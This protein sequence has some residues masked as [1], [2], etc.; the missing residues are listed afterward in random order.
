MIFDSRYKKIEDIGEGVWSNVYKVKDLRTDKIYT[1]KLFNHIDADLIYEK[2]SAED[3]HHITKLDHPNLL[4]II[5]FGN[6]GNH[7]YYLSDYY[8]GK[9]LNDFKYKPN[10]NEQFY[11]IVAQICYALDALHSQGLIHKDLKLENILYK[12]VNNKPEI[13]VLDYGFAKIDHTKNQQKVTGTLPYIAPEILSGKKMAVFQ[14]DFYSLGVTLYKI[15]TG[16]S[17]YSVEQISAVMAGNPHNFFPKFP[18]EIN[19]ECPINIEKLILKLLEK[20]PE[21]RFPDVNSIINFINKMQITKKFNFSHK[22]SLVNTMKHNSYIAREDYS[23]TLMDYIPYLENGNGKTVVLLGGDGQGKDSILTLFEYHLLTNKYF[24]FDYLCTKQDKDPFFA[25]INEFKD[26]ILNN[27]KVQTELTNISSKFRKYLNNSIEEASK[28]S[29]NQE[30]LYAD[31]TSA[32]SFLFSLSEE[33]P[34]IFIIRAEQYISPETISFINLAAFEMAKKPIMIILSIND[35]HQTK[36]LKHAIYLKV[37]PLSFIDTKKYLT[38]LLHKEVP[39]TFAQEIHARSFGIPMFVRDILIDL[40]EKKMIWVKEKLNFDVDLKKYTLPQNLIH[41]IYYRMSHL[42]EKSYNNLQKLS[43]IY[44]PLSKDL[45]NHLLDLSEEK[46]LWKLLIDA[47]N[48]EIIYEQDGYYHFTFQEIRE[49]LNSEL[50]QDVRIELSK[51][52]IQYY[53][54]NTIGNSDICMGLV[55]NAYLAD[56]IESVRRFKLLLIDTYNNTYQQD[57]A[58]AEICKVIEID[59]SHKVTVPENELKA[60]LESFVNKAEM[61]GLIQKA[62]DLISEIPHFPEMFEKYYLLGTLMLRLEKYSSAEEYLNIAL[63]MAMTGKYRIKVLIDLVW[64]YTNNSKFDK[65]LPILND[66]NGMEMSMELKIAYIDRESIYLYR[67][68]RNS[69][70]ITLL[71]KFLVDLPVINETLALLK[72]GSLYNNLGSFYSNEKNIADAYKHFMNAKAIWEKLNY[73]RSLGIVYNNLGDLSLRQG[74]T[75]NALE[76]FEKALEISN[77]IGVRRSQVLAWLNFGET[78][79]KLGQFLKAEEHL[80]KAKEMC[81]TLESKLFYEGIVYNLAIVRSKIGS[82]KYYLDFIKENQPELLTGQIKA[83]TPLTKTYFY[84]LFETGQSQKINNL[85]YNNPHLDFSN[86]HEE[87]FYY[88]ILGLLSMHKRDYHT[89]LQNINLALEQSIKNKS[90]YAQAIN[91]IRQTECYLGLNR[92]ENAEKSFENA[93]QLIDNYGFKYWSL[94]LDILS[95][96]IQ[97]AQKEIPL[98]VLL[99]RTLELIPV[100]EKND[101]Y[102]LQLELYSIII[103]I[104]NDLKAEKLGLQYF[105]KYKEKVENNAKGLPLEDQESYYRITKYNQT[106]HHNLHIHEV[107]SRMRQNKEKWQEHLYNLLKLEELSRI[108]FSLDKAITTLLA[109]DF[110]GIVLNDEIRAQSPKL[111]LKYNC[112]EASLLTHPYNK[113]ILDSIETD[114]IIAMKLDFRH[115][116]FIPLRLKSARVGCLIIADKGELEF[117]KQDISLIKMLKLHLTTMLIRIREFDELNNKMSLVTR[118]MQMSQK[119]LQILDQDKLEKQIVM[120]GIE[121]LRG[122]RGFMIIRDAFGNYS[123]KIS[124]DHKNNLLKEQKNISMTVVGDVQNAMIPIYTHNILEDSIYKSSNSLHDFPLASIYCAPVTIDNNLHCILYF[125]SLAD[126]AEELKINREIVSMFLVQAAVAIKNAM[127]YESLIKKNLELK[128]LDTT[129]DKF[130]GIVSH[131][132]NTPL[133]TLKGYVN[134]LKKKNFMDE[135]ERTETLEK[136]EKSVN[137]LMLS[138]KDIVLLNK[139]NVMNSIPFERENVENLL[140]IVFSEA[141]IINRQYDRHMKFKMEIE[142]NLP[143][144]EVNWE[145]FHLMIYS[146][147]LNS[148]RFTQDFG[149]ITMGVRKATFPQEKIND[150]DGVVIYIQDNG[151][152]IP[153]HELTNIFKSFYELNDIYSHRSGT[154]EYRSSGL[155]LGLAISN[156]IAELHN[157]KIWV[158]SKE[159]EGTTVFIAFSAYKKDKKGKS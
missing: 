90:S 94:V 80:C 158:N 43:C 149:F 70:A 82:F 127:Q 72:L 74:D 83:L 141:E 50:D 66:L 129:K 31:F 37:E 88:Q 32:K 76:Y 53:K 22:W 91:Y 126:E 11:E 36:E 46:E 5:K 41:S 117:R 12:V 44:S 151:T 156:R 57:K 35:P 143:D 121:L 21:D 4:H 45:I 86:N 159:N 34:L 140:S 97:L 102:A 64:L 148:I 132:L 48:N 142:S 58:F 19:P 120:F 89:A 10:L 154:V 106:D 73:N 3:M 93:K 119:M 124:L 42:N 17:P 75:K 59:F 24:V 138:I 103:Q 105:R 128:T 38:K 20:N 111:F 63:N 123:F 85:L 92:F 68:G 134:K 8:D 118:I 112:D 9:P 144:I 101:I 145:G 157:A 98:R 52:F 51:K 136:V 95:I 14:S 54:E 155:G 65:A 15:M 79:I 100:I 87:E 152:G 49:R 109:P 133:V 131:E 67:T 26:Y 27:D 139:Y 25:L 33:R 29:E 39:E 6:H 146:I 61:T 122:R 40:T 56:D 28:L 47:R 150:Q 77:K 130:I 23:H 147:I 137:K 108:K 116:L 1:L 107:G 115:T 13:K 2:L 30:E 104:Y 16:T 99:R 96:K 81:L 71:E 110:Y 60:D 55:Q 135:N 78:Y 114:K 62:I 18:R 113:Y 69:D 7:I 153:N 84:Y 125:D